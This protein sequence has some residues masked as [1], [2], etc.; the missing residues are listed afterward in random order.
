MSIP[1]YQIGK[2]ISFF[3]ESGTSTDMG[4]VKNNVT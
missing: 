2:V 3:N 1:K 4:T